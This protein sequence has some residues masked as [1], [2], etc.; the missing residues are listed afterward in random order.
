[1]SLIEDISETWKNQGI[2]GCKILAASIRSVHHVEMCAKLGAHAATIPYGI[3]TK[4][5]EHELTKAGLEKF[6]KDWE[7]VR[8]EG[9]A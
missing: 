3:F 9:R 7:A 8:S 1:L 4:L 6:L 5:M 2:T